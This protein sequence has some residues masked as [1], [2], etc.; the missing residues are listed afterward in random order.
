MAARHR[1]GGFALGRPTA[2][3]CFTAQ[4]ARVAHME[5]D[6]RTRY[7]T[8]CRFLGRVEL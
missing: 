2:L 8:G 3:N 5:Q 4:V 1:P 6:G 7:L